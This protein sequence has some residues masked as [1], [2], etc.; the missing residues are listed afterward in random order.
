MARIYYKATDQVFDGSTYLAERTTQLSQIGL[1]VNTLSSMIEI[2]FANTPMVF[3][4]GEE[5]LAGN[6]IK[7]VVDRWYPEAQKI[8]AT[9]NYDYDPLEN[10]TSLEER[11]L[12]EGGTIAD[13]GTKNTANTGTRNDTRTDNLA[14]SITHGK[15]VTD[16]GTSIS[17]KT[18]SAYNSSSYSPSEKE[19]IT[20]T[21]TSTASGTDTGSNTGTQTNLR[22]DNLTELVTNDLLKTKDL[23]ETGT[24]S[25][26]GHNGIY[27]TQ[28]LIKEEREIFIDLYRW[29]VSKFKEL[30][31]PDLGGVF[32]DNNLI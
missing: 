9:L 13:T 11:D 18:V 22:T 30:F 2:A 1:S 10:F 6:A 8:Y 16:G 21:T 23:T 14:S 32:Y 20:P 28:R 24:I 5:T 3:L 19:T 31:Q 7:N 25:K 27:T 26:H 17:E 4:E 29:Y 12:A 15:V